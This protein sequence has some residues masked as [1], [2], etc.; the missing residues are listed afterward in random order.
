MLAAHCP[1]QSLELLKLEF[2]D[3]WPPFQSSSAFIHPGH[4][5]RNL[6]F[7]T[8]L[9]LL[10]ISTPVG[11]DLDDAT[12]SDMARAWPYMEELYLLGNIHPRPNT[13]TLLALYALAEYCPYLQTLDMTLDASIVPQ[14][15]INPGQRVFQRSLVSL[16]VAHSFGV[17]RFISSI[18]VDLKQVTSDDAYHDGGNLTD[19]RAGEYHLLWNEVW[20]ILPG[21]GEVRDEEWL[22][23]NS[24]AMQSILEYSFPL[25]LHTYH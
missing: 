5:F 12:I 13:P 11:H 6:F 10:S 1:Y 18:F 21:L 25:T 9:T 22:H 20:K 14:L 24:W 19:P 16:N 4:L 17:A 15:P 2:T 23:G 8:N 3:G 7:F